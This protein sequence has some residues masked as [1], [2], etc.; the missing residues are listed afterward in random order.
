MNP[1]EFFSLI[2][3]WRP[4]INLESKYFSQISKEKIKIGLSWKSKN[5]TVGKHKS[6]ELSKLYKSLLNI[7]NIELINLQYGDTK[8]EIEQINQHNILKI[9]DV[10]I[11]LYNDLE[12]LFALIDLCDIIITT[13][14][15]TAH[16]SGALG[17]KTLL[18]L[19]KR[20]GRIWYWYSHRSM[21]T[22]YKSIKII[23]QEED[24][25]WDSALRSIKSELELLIKN[26]SS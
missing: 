15:I 4:T 25:D 11:D 19:P 22:W 21:P 5:D 18:L 7:D 26:T 16:I 6:L 10:G 1:N 9:K 23:N 17:K 13:S 20:N 24:L 8:D 2:Y 3:L 14:N 12:R